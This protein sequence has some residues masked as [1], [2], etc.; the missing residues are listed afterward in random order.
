MDNRDYKAMN[1]DVQGNSPLGIVMHWV[2]V[3]DAKPKDGESILGIEMPYEARYACHREDRLYVS[4]ET[5][6]SV[7]ITH[8]MYAPEPPCL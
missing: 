2:A 6:E 8:W 3:G 7:V 5:G 1:K 4:D